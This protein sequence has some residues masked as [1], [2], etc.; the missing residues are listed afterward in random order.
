M[1]EGEITVYDR[2]LVLKHFDA[3]PN[4][5]ITLYVPASGS[6]YETFHTKE[7]YVKRMDAWDKAVL[8]ERTNPSWYDLRGDVSHPWL[9]NIKTCHCSGSLK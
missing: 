7:Q 2:E 8:G 3:N 1:W 5:S 9:D 6:W 4:E